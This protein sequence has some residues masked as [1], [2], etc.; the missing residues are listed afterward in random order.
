MDSL[1]FMD[2]RAQ[3]LKLEPA[4]TR[5]LLDAVA[6]ARFILGPEVGE[7]EAALA[8]YVGTRE[9]VCC[10][11]GTDALTLGLL[12]WDVGP[13]EAVFCP[14]FTFFST[15]EAVAL[16]GA[17]PVF[18]DIDPVTYNID[19]VS[20][21]ERIREVKAAGKLRPRAIIPVDLFGLPYDYGAVAALAE[22]HG[23]VILEDA[24]QGF[25]GLYGG[26]RA[27]SL[28]H[29]GIT[30]FFPAKPLGCYGDGGAVFT[31]NDELA[32]LIRSAR[33]HGAGGHRYEHVRL[34]LNSRLDTIQAAILLVKLKAF[35][36]ELETRQIVA[37]RYDRALSGRVPSVPSVPG[38]RLSS[39]AQYTVRVP[40]ASREAIARSMAAQGVPTAIYYP[41]CLHLQPA[42]AG[43]GGCPGDL[44]EAERASG[45]VL[46]LPMHPYLTEADQARV[47]SALLGA[48]DGAGGDRG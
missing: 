37:G 1:P 41:K 45:E 17:T 15:A 19:P 30:S 25:G 47:V 38:G 42:F 2:L 12:A 3:Y 29:A 46:S 9:C 24:A 43:L 13:G 16:R 4:I 27:G 14:A 35:P 23:L 7:L 31:D 32:D 10:A 11:N 48:L 20:L 18:V 40:A 21:G 34:G 8:G 39:W 22:E 26:R 44:P 5:A 6:S 28:G 36:G 33:A